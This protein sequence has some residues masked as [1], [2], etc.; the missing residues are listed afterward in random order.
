MG[1]PIYENYSYARFKNT[2]EIEKYCM[3]EQ[4]PVYVTKNGYGSLVVMDIKYYEKTIQKMYEAKAVIEGLKDLKEGNTEEGAETMRKLK[5]KF[6][7]K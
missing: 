6:L 2:V 7:L 3:K 4:G 5:E 1:G